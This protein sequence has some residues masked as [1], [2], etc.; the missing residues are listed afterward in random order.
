SKTEYLPLRPNNL[1]FDAMVEL[2]KSLG[3][4][5]LHLGGGYQENDSL[6]KFKS[7]FTN[8]N[9]FNYYIGKNILNDKIYHELSQSVMNHFSFNSSSDFF[10]LYRRKN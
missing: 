9:H 7:L 1:L 4:K 3:L 5:A 10:P 2:S 8:N 6:F